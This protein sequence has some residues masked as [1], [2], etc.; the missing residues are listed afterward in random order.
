[1][2]CKTLKPG[3]ECF[4]M[5]QTGCQYNGGRCYPVVEQC[6]GCGRIKEFPSGRFCIHFPDPSVKWRYGV[7]N[8]ATHVSSSNGG[9]EKRLNPLKASKRGARG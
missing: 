3:F 6:E 5:T 7:C 9:R 8:M 4:F 1:M 2:V